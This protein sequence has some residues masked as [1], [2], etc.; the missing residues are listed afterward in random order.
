[1]AVTVIKVLKKKTSSNLKY[2]R[3]VS[4]ASFL[5]EKLVLLRSDQKREPQLSYKEIICY[6][7]ATD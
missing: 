6:T 2:Q 4:S 7:M 1:M 5:R 3:L